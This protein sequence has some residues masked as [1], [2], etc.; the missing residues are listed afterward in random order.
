MK[1]I[2]LSNILDPPQF[3]DE[4]IQP[5]A[6]VIYGL[7]NNSGKIWVDKESVYW[8][9]CGL[10]YHELEHVQDLENKVKETS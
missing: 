8:Q 10:A 1:Q 5:I 7:S 9:A 6:M 4:E 2:T 3:E